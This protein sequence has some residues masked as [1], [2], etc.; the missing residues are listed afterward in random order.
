PSPGIRQD[1]S[2]AQWLTALAQQLVA[3]A[4][5][6]SRRKVLEPEQDQLV[7]S[8]G[9]RLQNAEAVKATAGEF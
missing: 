4:A 3:A 5:P 6:L 9:A 2:E 7:R 1:T 8:V